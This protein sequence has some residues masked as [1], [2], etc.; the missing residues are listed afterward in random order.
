[1]P[2]DS[3]IKYKINPGVFSKKIGQ[4][5]IILEK[6]KKSYRQLNEVAG[7][8]WSLLT[9][10][11]ALTHIARQVT[12][13]YQVSPKQARQDVEDFVSY[14]MKLGYLEKIS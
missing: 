2:S 1:M 8:I 9:T 12:Q 7:F 6:D 5:W 4:T 10:P 14:L 3:E 13:N 11:K